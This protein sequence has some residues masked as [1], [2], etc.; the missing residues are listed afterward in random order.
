MANPIGG[1]YLPIITPFSGGKV[2]LAGYRSLLGYY[3]EKGIHGIVP[4]GTTG[5]CPT[6]EE[7]EC[8]EIVEATVDLAGA[9]PIFV[10][11]SANSTAK[12]VRQIRALDQYP[13]AGFLVTS[14]YYNLPS[15]RGIL[16]HYRALADATGKQIL[17]YNIPYRTGRNLE[18]ETILELSSVPNIVGI[19]DSC[20]IMPQSI[21]L[22]RER[23]SRFA[24][25]TGEDLF[26]YFNLVSGGDGGILASAHVRTEGFLR[27][28]E[29]VR[30]GDLKGALGEWNGLARIIPLLFEEPNPAPIKY[31]LSRKGVIGSAEV[32]APL[33]PISERLKAT[34]DKLIAERVL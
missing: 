15:Q 34:I 27:V 14:P 25:L 23:D 32:R 21:E 2:D 19:K 28:W 5:E 31:I 16:D 8:H 10:G 18:N 24:V 17:I 1:V 33:A 11:I 20:G 29:A 30:R 6:I 7:A 22:L 9:V 4:L 12:G 13:V 3:L 26:F